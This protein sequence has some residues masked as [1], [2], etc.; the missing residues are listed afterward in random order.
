MS[1]LLHLEVV[2]AQSCDVDFAWYEGIR[3]GLWAGFHHTEVFAYGQTYDIAAKARLLDQVAAFRS[4]LAA[5]EA[6]VALTLRLG[7]GPWLFLIA[8][9]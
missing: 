2:P 7:S 3:A 6:E 8:K 5:A 9:K 4:A 1:T